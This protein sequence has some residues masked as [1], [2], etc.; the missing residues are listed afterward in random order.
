M[1][2]SNVVCHANETIKHL[3]FYCYYAKFMWGLSN[4]AFNISSPRSVRHLYGSWLNQF[5][6]KLKRQVLVGA[7]A[8]CWVIW[9]SK[10]DMIFDKSSIKTFMQVLYRG[11]HWLR[12][13]AQIKRHDQDKVVI[14]V[15]CRL[16]EIIAMKFFIDHG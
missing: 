9:L 13:W 4:L 10:N 6:G 12:F 1:G 11:T 15:A 7:S 3:F 2:V 16:M 14:R 5:G 8:F